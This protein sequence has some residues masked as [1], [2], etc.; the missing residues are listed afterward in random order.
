MWSLYK[1][2]C[3]L[4]L[5]SGRVFSSTRL[6]IFYPLAAAALTGILTRTSAARSKSCGRATLA[7]IIT[8]KTNSIWMSESKGWEFQNYLNETKSHCIIYKTGI[9]KECWI[10][11]NIKPANPGKMN[12][13][14]MN[15]QCFKNNSPSIANLF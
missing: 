3:F 2:L 7:C 5:K 6:K 10:T 11:N 12:G 15:C 13:S 1:K 14:Y 9:E 4:G 8:R